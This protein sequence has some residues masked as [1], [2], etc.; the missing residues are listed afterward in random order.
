M[1]DPTEPDS[2]EAEAERRD[3]PRAPITLR[4]DYKRL[5]TFFADY[6][7][8][9]STGGTFIRTTRPLPIGTEFKFVLALPTDA[10]T[11][12]ALRG[13]VKWITSEEDASE[14]HPA[15]MGIQF[16]FADDAE[17]THVEALVADL[18]RQTLGPKLADKLLGRRG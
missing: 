6:T 8:N 12:V 3:D 5:N 18:M 11:E 9:I 13:V 14:E 10:S 15:G 1:A 4:V 17:R 2:A 7:K 16:V